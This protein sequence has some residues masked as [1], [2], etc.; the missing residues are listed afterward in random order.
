[1]L[2]SRFFFL[3]SFFALATSAWA[4]EITFQRDSGPACLI[5]LYSSEGCSSCPPAEEWLSH[6]KDSPQLW[7]QIFPVAFHVDYWNG[8]GWPDRFARPVYTDRQRAYAAKQKQ[9]SVYTPEFIV[10]G[11]EWRGWFHGEIAPAAVETHGQLVLKVEPHGRA[12]LAGYHP[13]VNAAAGISYTLHVAV[14][15]LGIVSEVERGENAGRQLQHDFVV[16]DFHS[17]TLDLGT[18]GEVHAGPIT[19]N[20][21]SD[22]A[23]AVVAWVS[24]PE[25]EVVQ[26]AGGELR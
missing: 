2:L 22:A 8:L 17:Q 24:T 16:L 5:E 10:N 23:Q 9:D 19:C 6:L 11:R 13:A 15:G 14:L 4:G 1:M 7:Q 26:I 3:G 21:G 25:T 12:V 18:S 20:P